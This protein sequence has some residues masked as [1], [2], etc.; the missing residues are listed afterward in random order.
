[1]TIVQITFGTATLIL[2]AAHPVAAQPGAPPPPDQSAPPPLPDAPLPSGQAQPSALPP[3]VVT[4]NVNLR[5]GPG[6]TYTAI[7]TIPA[8]AP[9]E[10]GD[11][12]GQWCQ[13]TWQGQHGYVIQTSIGQGGAQAS[14]RGAPPPG[15]IAGGPAPPPPGY[16]PTPVYPAPPPYPY[17]YYRP[18]PYY[19]GYYGPYWRGRYYHRW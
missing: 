2:L 14:P 6:T 3:A 17:P 9:V 12:I 1:M 19:Y 13:V 15:A 10:V 16:Y 8:G 5:Q 18:Y 7:T 11:C 4:T